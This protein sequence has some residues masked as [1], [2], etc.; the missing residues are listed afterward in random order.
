[1]KS[2]KIYYYE[3][4]GELIQIDTVPITNNDFEIEAVNED[5]LLSKLNSKNIKVN[6]ET[7]EQIRNIFDSADDFYDENLKKDD[8]S[9]FVIKHWVSNRSFGE[10]IDMYD[11]EEIKVPDMQRPLVWD[12]YRSSRLIE[13]IVMGLPIPPLFLLEVDNNVYEIIDGYQRLNTLFNYVKGKPWAG[14]KIGKKHIKSKLS[15]N[16]V[17][18]S[19]R[20]KAFD[21]L[22]DDQKRIIKRSTIPLIEFKQLNPDN[23]TSK[24]LIFERINTGSEKLS[25]MQIRKALAYGTFIGGLYKEANNPEFIKLFS[26]SQLKKDLN[27][28]AFLRILTISEVANDRFIPSQNGLENILN[29]Y[30]EKNKEEILD[31]KVVEYIFEA[32]KELVAKFG[33]NNIFRRVNSEDEYEGLMNTSILESLVGAVVEQKNKNSGYKIEEH[34]YKEIMKII[35]NDSIS[36]KKNNPFSYSTGTIESM[37]KRFSICKDIIR[38]E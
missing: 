36:G 17:I 21:D 29:E 3:E 10:L 30:C 22:N 15:K 34:R 37:K 14:D 6:Y 5:E 16:L 23:Y 12:S 18:P 20:G 27:V 35:Y 11:N 31:D 33:Y 4:N 25:S 19:I 26:T 2:M 38:G 8:N 7:E 28:E 32:V 9:K 1:M 24:Y 13:S